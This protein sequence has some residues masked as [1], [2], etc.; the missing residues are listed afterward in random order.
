M[1]LRKQWIINIS[2]LVSDCMIGHNLCFSYST[3]LKYCQRMQS[4]S[5]HAPA[6]FKL[7]SSRS[8]QCIGG[9]IFH[10]RNNYCLTNHTFFDH[11]VASYYHVASFASPLSRTRH[12][13]VIGCRQ[14]GRRDHGSI[15]TSMTKLLRKQWINNWTYFKQLYTTCALKRDLLLMTCKT[16]T[17][18]IKENK[19]KIN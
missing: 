12:S 4:H 10:V 18:D 11:R 7:D 16:I 13:D 17:A 9:D 3:R 8:K 1:I 6:N 2:P 19:Q 14:H 5:I 15:S